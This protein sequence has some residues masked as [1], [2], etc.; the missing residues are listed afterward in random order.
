MKKLHLVI[1]LFSIISL[2]IVNSVFADSTNLDIRYKRKINQWYITAM[3]CKGNWM[4]SPRGF[5]TVI[6][7]YR[8]FTMNGKM[9]YG[10]EL[11]SL[12]HAIRGAQEL[13]VPESAYQF[14]LFGFVL[15]LKYSF[16]YKIS[17]KKNIY[18][19]TKLSNYQ[20]S[21]ILGLPTFPEFNLMFMNRKF[22]KMKYSWELGIA[23]GDVIPINIFRFSYR[24]DLC[25]IDNG[26]AIN[27]Y[28]NPNF[29]LLKKGLYYHF[30]YYRFGPHIGP[31]D[32]YPNVNFR[33][34]FSISLKFSFRIL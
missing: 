33:G 25:F 11:F 19:S 3:H 4:T 17:E 22:K 28:K 5:N 9:F 15:G 7:E 10:I 24:R 30:P 13:Y 1:F 27:N 6:L 26:Y 29:T 14:L 32:E 23:A 12:I 2:S 20:V 21:S 31:D 16:A 34:F 8:H 18:L